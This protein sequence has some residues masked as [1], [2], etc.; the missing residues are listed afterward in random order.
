MPIDD[1]KIDDKV[2]TYD[3]LKLDDKEIEEIDLEDEKEVKG[4]KD[5]KEDDEK[6]IK[7]KEDEKEEEE[8]KDDDLAVPPKKVEILKAYPDIFKK[9]PYLETAIYREQAFTELVGSVD[10]AK[11]LIEKAKDYD[12]FS[13]SLMKGDL[14]D[15][16]KTVKTNDEGAYGQ[17][18]D[19]ILPTLSK[20]D[21]NAYSWLIGDVI[22]R[23]IIT[24]VQE[25]SNLE[26]NESTK[27]EGRNLR[28]AAALFHKFMF[29]NTNLVAPTKFSGKKSDE[30]TKQVEDDRNKLNEERAEILI[31]RYEDNL[32]SIEDRVEN[33]LRATISEH[34]DT[35]QLMSPYTKKNAVNDAIEELDGLMEEDTRFKS[36]IDKLWEQAFNSNFNAD[37]IG[38]IRSAVLGKAKSLLPSV[39]RKIRAEALKQANTK[40][41][42]SETRPRNRDVSTKLDEPKNEVRGSKNNNGYTK[43][44]DTVE[45][46]GMD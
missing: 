34:I 44:M 16:L 18:I 41:D 6:E 37:S 28:A 31:D 38:K 3:A 12:E 1:I 4:K 25:A 46:F 5:D 15:I 39:I 29:A 19:N 11:E 43:G 20:V 40:N 27:E 9:F 45:Y 26:G 14:G 10:D 7:L 33:T 42:E 8:F 24:A 13:S 32:T 22:R 35:K 21:N 36:H 17:I 30:G 23:S 2:D